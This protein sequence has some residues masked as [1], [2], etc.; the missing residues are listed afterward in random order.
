[1][2]TVA[3]EANSDRIHYDEVDTNVVV[4]M[5]GE[6]LEVFDTL[7]V[8]LPMYLSQKI[9]S[10]ILTPIFVEIVPSERLGFW[11][12]DVLEILGLVATDMTLVPPAEVFARFGV[13]AFYKGSFDNAF[14]LNDGGVYCVA[15]KNVCFSSLWERE[16]KMQ[17]DKAYVCCEASELVWKE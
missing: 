14:E 3:Y 13:R 6:K 15:R 17:I 8:P 4:R 16:G 5:N 12:Y 1:M 7:G 10:Y 11:E 2:E 9:I